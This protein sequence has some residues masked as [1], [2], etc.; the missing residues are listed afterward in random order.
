MQTNFFNKIITGDESWCFACDPE[1]NWQSS[2]WVNETYPRSKEL[3]F[4]RS[5]IKIMLTV[6]FDSQGTMHKEFV[7][8]GKTENAKFYKGI[9]DPLL[10]RI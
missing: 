6:F 7:P 1:T 8:E 4:Q 2:E 5:R 10:K 9:K 3:K